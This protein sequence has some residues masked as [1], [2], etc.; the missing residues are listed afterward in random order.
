[1]MRFFHRFNLKITSYYQLEN[2]IMAQRHSEKQLRMCF[3]M[4]QTFA[5]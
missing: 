4:K 3:C 5:L 1:M 2:E